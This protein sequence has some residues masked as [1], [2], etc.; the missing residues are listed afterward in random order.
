ME[1]NILTLKCRDKPG[2][3]ALVSNWITEQKGNII[4][5]NQYSTDA[6]NGT[7]F[8]RLKIHFPKT[9]TSLPQL[10]TR[11]SPLGQQLEAHWHLHNA[12]YQQRVGIL[13]SQYDH[14]LF[15][16][17]YRWSSK[18]LNINI[19][20]IASNHKT[21]EALAK[22]FAIPFYYLPSENKQQQEKKLLE[23]AQNSDL[24]VLAR[25][26]QILSPDFIK[27]YQKNIINIHHS[28]LP[29]FVGAAPYTQAYQRGVKII[30]A[31]AHYVTEQLDEGPI[32]TQKVEH[33]SHEDHVSE[34]KRK[35]KHLE[36]LVLLNALHAEIDHRII[37]DNN[38][39]IVFN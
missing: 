36:K 19:P 5:L 25:Y 32:I 34:L 35:G 18:E 21:C 24:L 14:C 11:F 9:H 10:Q 1:I 17:L 16:L 37:R 8:T 30:G 28:F 20:F 7:F 4:Q 38:K 6:K 29:S 22:Q 23:L 3:V 13:V 26:M 2:I 15:E 12:N 39:T 33:V 27:Q 31:T